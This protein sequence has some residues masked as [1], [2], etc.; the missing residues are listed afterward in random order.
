MRGEDGFCVQSE[1]GEPGEVISRLKHG[2]TGYTDPAASEA[3]VL[4]DVFTA[5]DCWYRT[6]DVMSRD[7][8]GFF[9]FVDRLGDTF[10]WKG[11]NVSAEEI[12]AVLRRCPGIED[13]AVYG[14]VVPA[15]EGRAGMAAV[16]TADGFD[17]DVL[18]EIVERYLPPYARPLFVRQCSALPMTATFKIC[19]AAM[20][21]DGITGGGD[22]VRCYVPG[23]GYVRQPC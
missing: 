22:P 7:A 19:K 3:K 16:V 10:R 14:V 15:Q 6:G 11:E 17:W 2:F 1:D 21:K 12:A 9:Y 5:G 20:A 13:A 4:R 23:E 8:E 18:A